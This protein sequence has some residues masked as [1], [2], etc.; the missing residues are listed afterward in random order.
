L[1]G[2]QFGKPFV[3]PKEGFGV[4][5]YGNYLPLNNASLLEIELYLDAS[6]RQ[7][8]SIMSHTKLGIRK[9]A[10]RDQWK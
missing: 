9:W 4:S 8:G 5:A 7:R 10:R 3:V 2:A 1:G 6:R